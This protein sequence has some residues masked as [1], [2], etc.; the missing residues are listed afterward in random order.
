MRGKVEMK[1][2]QLMLGTAGA[3]MIGML[4]G[5]AAAAPAIGSGLKT[6]ATENSGV[7]KAAYR[8]CW[9]HHGH[10][11]CRYVSRGY[12]Y[13]GYAPYYDG[14]YYGYGYGPSLG[15]YFGGG[16]RHW[17]HRHRHW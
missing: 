16:H 12:R 7:E 6:A 14:G 4:A 8:R 13:Y 17:G 1:L 5:P 10:R 11:H 9:W 15:L 3:V 2:K